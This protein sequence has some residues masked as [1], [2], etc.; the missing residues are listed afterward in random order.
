MAKKKAKQVVAVK[1]PKIGEKYIFKFAGGTLMGT[2]KCR[3]EKL[4]E[5]YKEPW[6]TMTVEKGSQHHSRTMY[7]PVSIYGI[8]RKAEDGEV[9]IEK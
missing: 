2:L 1:K 4:E 6:F 8:V 9:W 7:Y 5:F 3:S